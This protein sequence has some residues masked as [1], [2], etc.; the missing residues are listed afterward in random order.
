MSVSLNDSRHQLRCS[1]FVSIPS[2]A[3]LPRD[4]QLSKNSDLGKKIPISTCHP[5]NDRLVASTWQPAE[6]RSE[7]V[8]FF[9][10]HDRHSH[11]LRVMP[12][13]VCDHFPTRTPPP[14]LPR[15]RRRSLSC[16]PV[17]PGFLRSQLSNERR[18]LWYPHISQNS[19]AARL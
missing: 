5:F 14:P 13:S 15:G 12:S 4:T 6:W 16:P 9:G 18:R 7:S 2:V 11:H 1:R 17:G 10:P 19:W 3:T 8:T